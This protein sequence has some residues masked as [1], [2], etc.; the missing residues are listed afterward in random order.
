M[1]VNRW[2]IKQDTW[3]PLLINFKLTKVK[4]LRLFLSE[5]DLFPYIHKN[6]TVSYIEMLEILGDH[7]FSKY[8]KFSEE[9]TFFTTGYVYIRVR[10]RGKKCRFF[11]KFCVRTK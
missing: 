7:S 8:A 9:P 11:G 10:I 5:C 2:G 3:S 4:H 1:G 6:F